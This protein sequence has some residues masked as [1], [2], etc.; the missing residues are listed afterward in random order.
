MTSAE[1]REG[2]YQRRRAKREENKRKRAEQLGTFDKVFSYG[3]LYNAA[4]KICRNVRW[5]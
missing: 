2:R 5:K 3:N 1:R 4:S